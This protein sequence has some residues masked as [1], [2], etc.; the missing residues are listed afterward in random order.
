VGL[1]ATGHRIFWILTFFWKI[2]TFRPLDNLILFL[3]PLL[4]ATGCGIEVT[5]LGAIDLDMEVQALLT[6]RD[7]HGTK[8]DTLQVYS[9][10][11]SLRWPA[12]LHISSSST[13]VCTGTEVE[14]SAT[15]M[16][17]I[18]HEQWQKPGHDESLTGSITHGDPRGMA[19]AGAGR[20]WNC[21]RN[22][23]N[24]RC[25]KAFDCLIKKI[26]SRSIKLN[27]TWEVCRLR[28][29]SVIPNTHGLD[30]IGKNS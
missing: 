2:F 11:C 29:C 30:G 13:L 15:A 24:L 3:D 9:D 20:T 26:E 23:R 5:R 4:C 8:M 19:A 6:T 21:A 12:A 14:R 27:V 7:W 22:N 10:L 1:E 18:R 16:Y 28:P 25:C 17:S